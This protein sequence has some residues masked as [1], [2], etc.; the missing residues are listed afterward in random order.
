MMAYPLYIPAEDHFVSHKKAVRL[1]NRA[2]YE[3]YITAIV[4]SPE[5]LDWLSAK[6]CLSMMYYA[7]QK[8]SRLTKREN[9]K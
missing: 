7:A 6:A 3:G 8:N 2:F 1:I 5:Y 9:K 4:D